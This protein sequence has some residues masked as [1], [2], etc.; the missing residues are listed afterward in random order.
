MSVVDEWDHVEPC[1][2]D[3][4]RRLMYE[5]AEQRAALAAFFTAVARLCGR[6]VVS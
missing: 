1:A 2:Y 4:L 5:N 6:G 3:E